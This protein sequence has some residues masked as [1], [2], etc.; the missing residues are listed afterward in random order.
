MA[1]AATSRKMVTR[2]WWLG[3]ASDE[4]SR[5]YLQ[6]RL[7][8]LSQ[9]IFWSYSSLL[10]LMF[11]LYKRYPD[12]EPLHNNKIYGAG[13]GGMVILVSIWRGWLARKP[14]SMRGLYVVDI[15]YALFS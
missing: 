2:A 10:V 12:I 13:A 7:L 8:V 6:T 1:G 15:I 14:L 11:L 3:M 4:E 9:L 5:A